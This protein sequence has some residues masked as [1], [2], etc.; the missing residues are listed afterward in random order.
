MFKRV[1][2]LSQREAEKIT[3]TQYAKHRICVSITS[4][5]DT[6]GSRTPEL[7]PDAWVAVHSLRFHDAEHDYRVANVKN[8][9]VFSQADAQSIIDFLKLHEDSD[10]TEVVVHC[11]AGISRSAAVA[12]AIAIAYN[13]QFPE[14]YANYNR[15]VFR[16]MMN[17][18]T[19]IGKDDE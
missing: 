14:H 9:I 2:F 1:Y 13:L 19:R 11:E 6:P 7:T 17:L 4:P 3:D 8:K 15:H 12:K 16:E 5:L 10:V 18:V